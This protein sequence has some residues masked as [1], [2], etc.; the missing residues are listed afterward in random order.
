M[1]HTTLKNVYLVINILL[2]LSVFFLGLPL[3]S[4][5]LLIPANIYCQIYFTQQYSF[6]NSLQLEEIPQTGYENRIGELNQSER[7]LKELGFDKFDEFYMR[8]SSDVIVFAYKHAELP[9]VLCQYHFGV[10]KTM[11]LMSG[12][13]NDY[14]L[15]TSNIKSTGISKLRPLNY[16]LQIFTE[17]GEEELFRRHI[18]STEFLEANGFVVTDEPLYNFRNEFLRKF[19]EAGK[20][21]KSLISPFQLLYLNYFGDK[22]KFAKTIQEQVLAKQLQLR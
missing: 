1:K 7:L 4:F 13:E 21:Y 9:I 14:A 2:G 10:L 17:Y 16:F 19:L 11:D 22:Y 15:T 12:F 3:W 18:Q 8:A 6:R 20:M 5:A